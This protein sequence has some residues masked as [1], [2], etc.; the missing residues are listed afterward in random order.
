MKIACT[1]L[2]CPDWDLDTIL[3]RFKEYGYDGVDFR[4]LGDEMEVWRLEAFTT[5]ADET[6][7]KIAESGLEVS[8]FSS[9]ARMFNATEED[10]QKS[11]EEVRQ[12]A[13]LCR[14]FGAPMIRVFGG[15]LGQTPREQAIE[16][17]VETLAEMARAAGPEVKLAVETHD[18]WTCSE[19][20]AQVLR[21]VDA[22]NVGALWDLH[23]PFRMCGESPR[24]TYENIGTF[25]IA[26]HLKD[27]RP[28]GEGKYEYCLG[29]EGDVPLGEMVSL[30]A[31]GGYD[32]YLTLEWEKKWHPELAGPEVALP[33]YARYM[34]SLIGA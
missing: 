24:Q 6:A 31:E 7:R 21:Q 19:P 34:K 10:K 4:G 9:G 22:P 20:L 3:K 32:G 30:L 33:A 29:G 12:Y 28:V 2:A 27:S 15:A 1:T 23:H 17:A 26:T 16:A 14:R 8:A 5:G 25:T 18:D 13:R 11:L